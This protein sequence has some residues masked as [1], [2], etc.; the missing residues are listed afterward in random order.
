MY[1]V[2]FF[3]NPIKMK[4]LIILFLVIYTAYGVHAQQDETIF[5]HYYLNHSLVNPAA[6]GAEGSHVLT[7]NMRNQ[8]AGFPGAPQTYVVG[9]QGPIGKTFGLGINVLSENVASLSRYRLQLAY[10]FRYSTDNVKMNIGFSTEFHQ[11]RILQGAGN[12]PLFDTGDILLEDAVDGL[13]LFDATLGLYGIFKEK[14][15][16]SLSIPN[17]IRARLDNVSPNSQ[18]SAGF[19]QYYM[20]M[21]GHRFDVNNSSVTIEPSMMITKVVDVPVII[22]ANIKATFLDEKLAAGVT[23]RTGPSTSIGFMLGTKINIMKVYYSYDSHMGQF[24]TYN[25]G[26]HEVT[27]GFVFGSKRVVPVKKKEKKTTLKE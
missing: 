19:L 5:K 25:E 23:F 12:D 7:L 26:S 1:K 8:Y 22:D 18:K 21:G 3:L 6:S 14:T 16:F 9:Y 20:L 27:V 11:M 2:R 24:A 13:K 15:F 17:L 4:N 10:V